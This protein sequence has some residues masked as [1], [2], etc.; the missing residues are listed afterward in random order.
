MNTTA[1]GRATATLAVDPGA[2][3]Q[4]LKDRPQW[5]VWRTERRD[6]RLTKTPYTVTNC[7]AESDNPAT[8][9]TFDRAWAKYQNAPTKFDGV[10]YVF[11]AD[12]PYCGVDLDLCL[13]PDGSFITD[14]AEQ[15]LEWLPSYTEVSP[16]GRGLKIIA[17]GRFP[18][19]PDKTGKSF[20][21]VAACGAAN[22][23]QPEVAVWNDRRYFAVTGQVFNGH[24]AIADCQAGIERL[25]Q[26]YWGETKT[27]R[28][29][30][31]ATGSNAGDDHGGVHA[32]ALRAMK[33][34]TKSM[35]DNGDGSKRL[36][37]VACRAV[38][39]DLSASAALATIRAYEHGQPFSREWSDAEI[40]Q[41]IA[42]AEHMTDRG[43]ALVVKREL[44]D[45]GNAER[46]AA[47]HGADVRYLATWGKWFTFN[48]RRWKVDD[49]G[50]VMRLAKATAKSIYAEAAAADDSEEAEEIA[51][52][53]KR[54]QARGKLEAMLELAKSE[55]PI[56]IAVDSL[57]SDPWL[58]NFE[59]GTVDLR[60]GELQ[61]HRRGDLI[62]KSTGIEYPDEPGV[63]AVLWQEFLD[64]IF[65]GDRELIRFLQRL[66]GSSLPGVVLEHIL[67]IFYGTGANGKSVFIETVMAALGEYAMKAPA[68]LLMTSRGDRHPTELADLCG[69]RLVAITET[70]DGQRLNEPLMKEATGG[71]TIRARRMR[72]DHWE[73]KPS[74]LAVLVTNYQPIVRGTDNGIWRR[75]RLVPFTVTIPEE[76]QDKA[77]THK[78]RSEL[79]AIAAWMVAGCLEWQRHGL[80]APPQVMAA[81][82]GYKHDSDTFAQWFE[83]HMKVEPL[84]CVKASATFK[85]YQTWCE[86]HGERNLSNR[87]F[88]ERMGEKI[89]AKRVSNGTW[90][91]GVAFQNG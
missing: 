26:T 50:A 64:S 4:E 55:E 9:T 3:P 37:C 63:D 56:P 20:R 65:N 57:D 32:E 36:I 91:D 21:G 51:A 34:A 2:I 54:S 24:A 27:P 33:R 18:I 49:T 1:N 30:A 71:D 82:E 59:N 77:L 48:G 6:G 22:G 90:Y 67:P 61:P 86:V 8:W 46:F 89:A 10:G 25:Y 28:K 44:T 7:K 52:F 19:P 5:I 17:R 84:G 39:Y 73:F 80:Q 40:L 47:L 87:R 29:R 83:E 38:E 70:G 79:P 15:A 76:R 16:S 14:W 66:M 35:Q 23:K 12:D 13:A 81:T 31:A 69:K 41:R 53:A 11:S 45:M 72:E 78:L 68:G 62:T 60:T 74:H 43:K 75:L 85:S 42:D 88:G 58:L